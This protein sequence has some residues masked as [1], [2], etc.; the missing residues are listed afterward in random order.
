MPL[1]DEGFVKSAG[2]F[3]GVTLVVL[4]GRA[5]PAAALRAGLS[6]AR[7]GCVVLLDGAAGID[8]SRIDEFACALEAGAVRFSGAVAA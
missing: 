4:G 2:P 8:P 1:R 7:G 3:G 6:A 5:D